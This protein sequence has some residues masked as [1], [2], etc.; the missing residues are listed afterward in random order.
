MRTRSTPIEHGSTSPADFAGQRILLRFDGVTGLARL[1]VNGQ[2]VREHYGGFTTWYAD[3]T[4][5]VTPGQEADLALGVTDK[6]GK[7]SSL[8]SAASFAT[9]ASS[10]SRT[11]HVTRLHVETDLDAGYRDAPLKVT[12]LSRSGRATA[13][14]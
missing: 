3:I 12:S 1:W 8:T 13:P 7:I 4:D 2:Y 14:Q 9:C 10:P 6:P 5:H 11:N